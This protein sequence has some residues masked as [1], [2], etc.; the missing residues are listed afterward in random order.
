MANNLD[1]EFEKLMYELDFM[2][3]DKRP[4]GWHPERSIMRFLDEKEWYLSDGGY[5]RISYSWNQ[6]SIFLTSNSLDKP[7]ERWTTVEAQEKI[8]QIN[9]IINQA[10]EEYE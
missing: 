7:K 9:E 5:S 10:I 2:L 3:T 1:E 6:H 8:M 4:E